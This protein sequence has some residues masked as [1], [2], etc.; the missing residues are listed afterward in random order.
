MNKGLYDVI[1]SNNDFSNALVIVFALDD[2]VLRELGGTLVNIRSW[3][4]KE[5]DI[6]LF[7][8]Y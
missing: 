1:R 2:G 5:Y 4:S 8:S 3:L 7:L 6:L